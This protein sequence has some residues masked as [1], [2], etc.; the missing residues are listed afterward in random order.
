MKPKEVL[1]MTMTKQLQ[2]KKNVLLNLKEHLVKLS[3]KR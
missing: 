1:E 2:G 3:K